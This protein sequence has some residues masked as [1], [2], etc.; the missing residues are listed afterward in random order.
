MNTH[1]CPI[2]EEFAKDQ[3]ARGGDA[4]LWRHASDE[5]E[6]REDEEEAAGGR[7]NEQVLARLRAGRE[8]GNHA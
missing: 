5:D 2:C 3:I 7:L 4:V 8:E 6:Q 1:T